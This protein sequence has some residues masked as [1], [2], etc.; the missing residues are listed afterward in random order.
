MEDK[1]YIIKQHEENTWFIVNDD[2]GEVV[3][4]ITKDT[5]VDYCKREYDN[6]DTDYVGEDGIINSAWFDLDNDY[7]IDLVDYDCEEL[8]K[9]VAW[10]DYIC[11]EYFANEIVKEYKQRL[12]DFE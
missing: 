1:K 10:F 3:N 9:F 2:T 7:H 6:V 4:I 8:D 11:V 12:L 5:V